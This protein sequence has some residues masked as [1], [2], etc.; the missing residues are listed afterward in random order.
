MSQPIFQNE[1]FKQK[2]FDAVLNYWNYTARLRASNMTE[3]IKVQD[4]LP[5]LGVSGRL[6]LIG[7]VFSESWAEQN[8]M[9]VTA[10]FKASADA[11]KIMLGS[12]EEWERLLQMTKAKYDATLEALKLGYREGVP[13]KYGRVQA[14]A[15][16]AAFR[17]VAEQ[18]GRKLVGRNKELAPGTLWQGDAY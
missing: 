8:L 7:Y 4:L 14:E 17:I 16:R 3:L 13:K 6:P 2:E 15:I 18:G 1:K 5:G 11:R 12:D 9:A 10:F